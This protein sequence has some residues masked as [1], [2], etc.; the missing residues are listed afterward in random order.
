MSDRVYT[1][2][3]GES[4]G[5]RLDGYQYIRAD[6]EAAYFFT[7]TPVAGQK[8]ELHQVKPK[9]TLPGGLW[10]L[11]TQH[12][13]NSP[14]TFV[15]VADKL[16]TVL[17]FHKSSIRQEVNIS[18]F[19][20]KAGIP[21]PHGVYLL[22][23]S[24]YEAKT[25]NAYFAGVA[26]NEPRVDY[27]TVVLTGLS[28]DVVVLD[29]NQAPVEGKN[30]SVATIQ[31]DPVVTQASLNGNSFHFKSLTPRSTSPVRAPVTLNSV[32][33]V[34]QPQNVLSMAATVPAM[35][36]SLLSSGNVEA[37]PTDI[38]SYLQSTNEK[39]DRILQ[40]LYK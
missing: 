3:L 38:L 7:Y 5:I 31:S 24:Q 30:N 15:I 33:P 35:A 8:S 9:L 18:Q 21:I 20:D 34:D 2:V 25:D 29:P 16:L 17:D 22:Y 19:E 32:K 4:V 13:R 14:A 12:T 40:L 27:D 23:K 11:L 28:S 39:M 37:P 6:G 26:L 1:K 10:K 36:M